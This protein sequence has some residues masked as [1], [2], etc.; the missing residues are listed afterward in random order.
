[1]NLVPNKPRAFGEM[2]RI[3]APGG[4]LTI[5]GIVVKSQIPERV[6]NDP[7]K[8]SECVSGALSTVGLERVVKDAGFVNFR[9][10]VETKWEKTDDKDLELASIVFYTQKTKLSV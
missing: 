10:L 2:F 3:L 7:A 6:R 4:Y 8:W 9:V 5:S 1:M